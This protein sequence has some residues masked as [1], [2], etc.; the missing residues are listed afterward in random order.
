M[1]TLQELNAHR[2]NAAATYVAA[3]DAMRAAYINLAAIDMA[4]TNRK[5]GGSVL[6]SFHGDRLQL[7]SAFHELLHFQ[8][9]PVI[10]GNLGPEIV[11]AAETRIAAFPIAN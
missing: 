5:V 2:T 1:S 4:L 10:N 8:F 6:Q 11:A 9:L 7:I 3:V